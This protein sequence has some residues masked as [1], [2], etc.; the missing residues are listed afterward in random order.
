M[1]H[2]GATVHE[3]LSNDREAGVNNVRLVNVKHKLWVLDDV[4]PESQWQTNTGKQN[5]SSPR[6]IKQQVI[7]KYT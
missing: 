3:G 2:R 4:H 5:K 1:F 7:L 6:D